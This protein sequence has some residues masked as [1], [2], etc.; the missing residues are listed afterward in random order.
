MKKILT[1]ILNL[2]LDI[3]FPKSK[4][5][6]ILE[7]TKTVDFYNIC[8]K[9]LNENIYIAKSIFNYRD[10]MV[11]ET[12]WELK[13]YKN[14]DSVRIFSEILYKEIEK[15]VKDWNEK[16]F[17]I[18]SPTYWTREK[19]RGYNQCELICDYLEK[20]NPQ[21]KTLKILNKRRSVPQSE[22]KNKD[23]RIKNIKNKIYIKKNAEISEGLYI[24]IDDV[25]TTG[26]TISESKKIL[27]KYG[28]NN[29]IA[30]SVA[31]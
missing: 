13:Y 20:I 2:L 7:K 4:I 21:M 11:K 9:S 8:Q 12:I 10:N 15:D 31:H 27:E 24:I 28:V 6:K 25:F 17:L 18:P 14:K 22:I 1:L 26:S 23:D 19:E 29:I 5:A 16:I 3:F 30:Y